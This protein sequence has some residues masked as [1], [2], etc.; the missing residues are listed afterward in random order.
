M[1]HTAF[2]SYCKMHQSTQNMVKITIEYIDFM[3]N[4]NFFLSTYLFLEL[5]RE[6]AIYFSA[7]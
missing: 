4:F 6:I 2:D 3:K 1:Q 7:R 5:F